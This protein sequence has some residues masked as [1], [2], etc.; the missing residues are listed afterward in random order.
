[1]R[2]A[3]GTIL[4][5]GA[6][7]AAACGPAP[8]PP[9]PAGDPLSRG[10]ADVV[11]DGSV[12]DAAVSADGS[13]VAFTSDATNLVPGDTN[14]ARDLFVRDLGTGVVTRLAEDVSSGITISANGRYVTHRAGGPTFV[15]HD[16]QTSTTVQWT[17][18]VS[19]ATTPVV[20]P[21]GATAVYG[22]PSSLGIFATACKVRDL[23]SG[24]ETDCP[25]GGPGFGTL[26]L[27]AVSAST[28]F[29][30]YTWSDQSGGGTSGR[31]VWDRQLDTTT[32]VP[33]QLAILGSSA[34]ISDDGRY[35][36]TIDFGDPMV[37]VLHDVQTGTTAPFPV[38]VTVG[39]T[40]PIDV[41]ADG[42]TVLVIS[43]SAEL[44]AGDTNGAPDAFLWHV[45]SGTVE[46]ISATVPGG[47]QLAS[48][49]LN[50]GG[51]PGQVL[52]DGSAAC[53]R[54]ADPVVAADTNGTVDAY[55][56]P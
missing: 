16:V 24:V 35:V 38:A 1:M 27:D 37:P 32:Q 34:S 51:S 42:S 39:S 46:R 4:L 3:L 28:R 17:H 19:N 5:A 14:G 29:V 12:G 25:A 40:V 21:D 8:P 41:S 26:A 55:L 44:V 2:P 52:A 11:G 48:G 23:A 49:A 15:V 36:A 47:D 10:N 45:V 6:V 56:L 31:Y 7:L 13:V 33:Q 54:A 22:A 43:E 53:L 20:S 18:T 50:C 30:L 9:P